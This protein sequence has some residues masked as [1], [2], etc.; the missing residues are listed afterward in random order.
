MKLRPIDSETY[1]REVLVHT[2]ALWAGRRDVETYLVQNAEIAASGY[3]KRHYRT[4]G[5]YDGAALLSS[6]K[7]YERNLHFGT[8]RLR[9][10][11]IG[12]VF[13][14][15]PLRGRGYASAMIATA[16]DAARAEG[17]DAAYLFSDIHP[18]FY[19]PLGFAPLP[20]RSFS[21]RA[22]GLPGNGLR[23]AG[24]HVEPLT[25]SDWAGVRRCFELG[26][27]TRPWGF[28]RTPLVWEWI[29]LRIE[30]ASEHPSGVTV[31]LVVRRG[32][33]IA[34]YAL[35]AR[36]PEHDAYVLDEFGFADAQASTLVPSLLRSAAGDLR[37]IVGWL[38]PAF[39]RERVPRASV[40]K[41]NTAIFMAAPLSASGT[42]W[43]AAA[44]ENSP[45]DGVWFT[46]HI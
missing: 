7:H 5:Y 29:R 34:A 38:P 16:L 36:A 21:L 9:A 1:A 39:A 11:G 25:A 4:I 20:S 22:D 15:E 32:R 33:A 14:P 35:G 45:G 23:D 17:Y 31:N 28:T 18:A 3:G 43:V 44:S 24:L 19:A 10:I 2:A 27:R 30:H 46:D 13:T 42:R 37:R 26:E 12:A 8:V 6:F 40:R 41:R